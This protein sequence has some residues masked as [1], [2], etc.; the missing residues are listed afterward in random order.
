[1]YFIMGKLLYEV[2]K[3]NESFSSFNLKCLY[4]VSEKEIG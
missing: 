1:M 2:E 4:I 3:V